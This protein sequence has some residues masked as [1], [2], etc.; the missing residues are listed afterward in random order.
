M[1]EHEIVLGQCNSSGWPVATGLAEYGQLRKVCLEE[2]RSASS[3]R[4]D[5]I[6]FGS[7]VQLLKRPWMDEEVTRKR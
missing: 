3:T 4:H 1:Q 2:P 6:A 5:V 7:G